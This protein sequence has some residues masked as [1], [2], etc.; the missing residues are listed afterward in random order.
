VSDKPARWRLFIAHPLPADVR[1]SL[2]SQLAAYRTSFPGARWTSPAAWH[3]TLLFLGSVD[4]AQVPGAMAIVDGVALSSHAYR[5]R[6]EKG[7]GRVH[8][9]DGV[10]WLGLSTGAATLLEYAR[11]AAADCPAGLT[12]G[13]TARR[14]PAAHLT[15]ARRADRALIDALR[16]STHGAPVVEWTVDR[17]CLMRSHLGPGGA[18]YE[19]LH[20]ATL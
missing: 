11:L 20:E 18:R 19:T 4:A 2:A 1:T 8:A 5:V 6:V 10:A 13:P 14:T 3:L 12:A 16:D 17:L 7:G 15:V 9:G